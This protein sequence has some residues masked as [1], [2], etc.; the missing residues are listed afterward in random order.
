MKT[1]FI[2]SESPLACGS[3]KRIFRAVCVFLAVTAALIFSSCY[4]PS[5]LYGTWCDNSGNKIAFMNDGSYSATIVASST[6][7][8]VVY[9]GT[10]T[11]LA[12]ALSFAKSDGTTIVTEWDIRGN[13][14]YLNWTTASGTSLS[15]TLYKTAN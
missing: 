5:P 14:L 1:S 6:E 13:M 3:T 15:L 8:P 9:D 2:D 7:D 12:N 4:E 10:Y 11:V